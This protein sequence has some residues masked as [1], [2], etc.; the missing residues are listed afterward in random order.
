MGSEVTPVLYGGSHIFGCNFN[1]HS[2]QSYQASLVLASGLPG[3]PSYATYD[4]G[5]WTSFTPRC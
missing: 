2:G 4:I 5:N 3:N 1:F